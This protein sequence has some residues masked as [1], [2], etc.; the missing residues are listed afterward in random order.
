M[1]KKKTLKL[2]FLS[3]GIPLVIIASYGLLSVQG[4]LRFLIP[5]L[6][7]ITACNVIALSTALY[8]GEKKEVSWSPVVIISVA[9]IVRCF[10]LFR[11]PELSDDIY[12]YLWDGIHMLQGNNPYSFAPLEMPTFDV[13]SSD[14]LKKINHPELVSIY[15]PAAQFIFLLGAF[16]TKSVT[17]IKI[18]LFI[19][20]IAACIIII[21]VLAHME[22]PVW[23]TVLYAWH[24]ISVLEIAASGHVDGVGIF[25]LILSIYILCVSYQANK[26]AYPSREMLL[27]FIAG[28]SFGTGSLV[29]LYPLFLIPAFLIMIKGTKRL[30]FGLGVIL[31]LAIFTMPFMPDLGNSFDTL[32]IYLKNWEFANF[33]FRTIR[34][35]TASDNIS[36]LLLLCSF[37]CIVMFVSFRL[38]REVL[39]ERGDSLSPGIS[40]RSAHDSRTQSKNMFL[41]FLKSI[42]LINFSFLLSTPT[43]YPWYAICLVC[44]FPFIAGPSG[45]IFSWSVFL[46]YYVIIDYAYLGQWIENSVIPAAIWC[47]PATGFLLHKLVTYWHQEHEAD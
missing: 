7:G 29:K 25:F 15:P 17:G 27:I 10:Y 30:L 22:L 46:S 1:A 4:D 21:K 47:A 24:P 14:L 45:I 38:W 31:S 13:M 28:A 18:S 12:R 32:K 40:G 42:Y 6:V 9:I 2:S 37:L 3:W 36:R 33:A 11:T 20:D 35:L 41:Y 23:R 39:K 43:L 8:Y 16:L 34:N 19:I 5:L 26:I 44:M